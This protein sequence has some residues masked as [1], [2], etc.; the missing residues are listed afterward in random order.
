MK[1][2]YIYTFG[3]KVNQYETRLISEKFKK[4]NFEPAEK[5]EDADIIVFNSCTVTAEADKECEYFLRKTLKLNNNPEI[6]L[7]GCLAK[8][9][10]QRLK[11]SFP[12]IKILENKNELY[13]NPEKQTIKTFEGRSRAFLKIQDG[14]DSFCS[15]CIVPFVRNEL[16]SKPEEEVL[17]EIEN[18]VKAGY[19][20]IVLT[21][22]HV[23]K[24]KGGITG[25]I[26]KIID[27]PLDFRIRISSIELNEVDDELISLMKDNP[28]KI[29]RHL[30]IPLQSGSNEILKQM[31]RHYTA[32]DFAKKI[33][34]IMNNL[35]DLALTADIITGFPGETEKQHKETYDFVKR[36][37]FSRFHIFRYSDREG[38]KAS[39]FADKVS[40][41]EIKKRSA[42][43]FEI[44]KI[45]RQEFL[46]K[47]TGTKR[48]AVSSGKNKA[49]TDNY[50]T[51][52]VPEKQPGIFE[53][54]ITK[55]SEV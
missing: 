52:N 22:I 37:S 45:K 46:N 48:K 40:A 54:E 44:D 15:Y 30:H 47:N 50:I 43:L 25:L 14:C 51:V 41:E 53:V 33:D 38:T 36:I 26:K 27:I 13:D 6:I 34:K 19:P 4:D 2:Y 1:K 29:C 16:W 42:D 49:L 9:K 11:D 5:P 31:N 23:G 10:T 28:G 17:A 12:G 32:K 55:D 35:S 8:N 21:G 20:E 39:Q 3:C 7:A 24:Y 18:F